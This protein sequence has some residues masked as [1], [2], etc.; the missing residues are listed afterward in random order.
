MVEVISQWLLPLHLSNASG[1]LHLEC[2]SEESAPTTT[3]LTGGTLPSRLMGAGG[4]SANVLKHKHGLQQ[5][6]AILVMSAG[7]CFWI[8]VRFKPAAL[9]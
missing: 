9:C 7:G 3:G 2:I 1:N 4:S 8:C 6:D 5:A